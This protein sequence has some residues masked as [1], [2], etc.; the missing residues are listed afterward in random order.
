MNG[1]RRIQY[2]DVARSIAIVSI[3]FNHAFNFSFSATYAEFISLPILV[4]VIKAALYTFSRIGVP[5]FLMISGALL[6][7]RNY[8][9]GET[10]RFLKHNWLQL[11][12]TTEIWLRQHR[13]TGL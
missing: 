3:T 11:L 13:I 7:P 8:G 9:G 12:I 10:T 2:L 5:L 4:N 1:N 6:L